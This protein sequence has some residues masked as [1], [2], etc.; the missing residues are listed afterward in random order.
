MVTLGIYGI[1]NLEGNLQ[2]EVHDHSL[3]IMEAGKVVDFIELERVTRLKHD[4]R[5]HLYLD[6]L[7]QDHLQLPRE[8]RIVF[9]DC[10]AGRRLVTPNRSIELEAPVRAGL[11]SFPEIASGRLFGQPVET[12]FCNHELAHIGTHLVF[13]G[14]FEDNSLLI[15][16]DGGASKSSCSVWH[17]RGGEIHPVHHSWE[18]HAQA[19]NFCDNPLASALLG[20]EEGSNL[21]LAG[22]LMGYARYGQPNPELKQWLRKNR[23]FDCGA[24]WRSAFFKSA[25]RDHGF[26]S[27]GFDLRDPF[28]MNIAACI[29]EDIQDAVQEFIYRYQGETGSRHLYYSGGVAL[30]IGINARLEASGRFETF[31][32]PPC[33][34]D[35]GLAL[36]AAA[37]L[38]FS[39]GAGIAKHSPFLNSWRTKAYRYA[40]EFDIRDLADR[41]AGGQIVGV[42]VGRAEVGPRALG[43]RSIV[44][45]PS[46]VE[47]RDRLS[48]EMKRREW[49]R[50]V[51][52]IALDSEAG[53]LFECDPS[54]ALLRYMLG[55]C[56]VLPKARSKIPGVVHVDGTARVQVVH[57]DDPELALMVDL[58]TCMRD[59]H[60]ILC[61][62]NTSFNRAGEP[63]VQTEEEALAAGEEMGLD[64]LVINNDLIAADLSFPRRR[65]MERI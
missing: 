26:Q 17:Y 58:L 46:S 34:N 57:A 2:T 42:C 48:M 37:M 36:G 39:F 65:T 3:V 33:C 29:Q 51:A 8:L 15:H 16:I 61:L 7:L 44:A 6:P 64:A 54:C 25:Q 32:I 1:P 55:E 43:H 10:I 49:Y 9:V 60:G 22:K 28:C 52:P 40:P 27:Q 59:R 5:L 4:N 47:I 38:E 11:A 45:S 14:G 23:W 18:L 31:H 63:L 19:M 30:N 62:I 41:I 35:S 20:L 53:Q 12:W 56:R 24:Q 13:S 50:P 21:T